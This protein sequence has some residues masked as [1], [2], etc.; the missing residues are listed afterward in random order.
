MW[1]DYVIALVVLAFTLTTWPMIRSDVR[2]PRLTTFPM[3]VGG[4]VLILA[5]AT[6]GLWVSVTI[7]VI[8][9]VGWTILLYRS[10]HARTS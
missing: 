5:Y 8:S 4:L 3:V 9:L 2:L 6:L 1:Q 7:E 10:L